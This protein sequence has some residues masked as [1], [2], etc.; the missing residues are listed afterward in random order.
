MITDSPHRYIRLGLSAGRS[1]ELL[2]AAVAEAQRV[3]SA[4]LTSVLTL[5][6]LAWQTGSSYLYL[7]SIIQRQIDPYEDILRHRRNGA[8][9]RLISA[10]NPPLMSVQRWILRSI[11]QRVHVHSASTAYSQGNSISRCAERHLGASW[12]VKMDL[13]DFFHSI[14]ERRIYSVFQGLGY[15]RLVSF[16]LARICTR[17]GLG[18]DLNPNMVPQYTINSYRM[19]KLGA[20]PQGSPT[21]GALANIVMYSCDEALNDIAAARGLVYTRYADDITF[22]HADRFDRGRAEEVIKSTSK[23]LRSHGFTL[24]KKKTKLYLQEV[25]RS[26]WD[27]W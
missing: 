21:S 20:L 2:N 4:G 1:R 27:Y 26:F 17:I 12:L 6:H 7:R 14:D 8:A 5:N 16:E 11:V 24:H 10:P 19:W 23:T 9:M 13:Q 25:E 3:E 22:S 15:N 18:P